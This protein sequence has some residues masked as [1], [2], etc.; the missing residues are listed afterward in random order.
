MIAAGQ[1]K[2][3]LFMATGAWFA[4]DQST[5]GLD[6][7]GNPNAVT[8]NRRTSALGQACAALST[9]VRVRREDATAP[10][11]HDGERTTTYVYKG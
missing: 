2:G 3:V 9:L 10:P 4:P 11:E 1:R 8:P 6:L 5:P 7:N